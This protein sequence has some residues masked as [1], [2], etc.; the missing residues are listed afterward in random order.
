MSSVH[1]SVFAAVPSRPVRAPEDVQLFS[2]IMDKSTTPQ[3]RSV[4]VHDVRKRER[5]REGEEEKRQE[6]EEEEEGGREREE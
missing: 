4:A 6:Q 5:E 1:A 3:R 2:G